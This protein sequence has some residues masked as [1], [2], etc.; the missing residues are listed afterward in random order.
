MFYLHAS[1]VG[2]GC[3]LKLLPLRDMFQFAVLS[4]LSSVALIVSL[5]RQSYSWCVSEAGGVSVA[6]D[7]GVGCRVL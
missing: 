3:F 1:Q 7:A 6:A 4:V 2:L 5:F